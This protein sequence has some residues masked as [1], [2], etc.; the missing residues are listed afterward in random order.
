MLVDSAPDLSELRAKYLAAQLK[1]SRREAL[2]LVVDEGLARGAS[3]AELQRQVLQEAQ[4][5]IGRLWQENEI[6]IAQEHMATAISHAMLA[7]LYDLADRAPSRDRKVLVACVDGEL[8]D[9]P[10]RLVADALDLAGFETRYL[11]ASVPLEGL[12]QLVLSEQPHLIA[13][14]V[15]MPFNVPAL[16]TAVARLRV[17]TGGN[18]PIAVG[19]GAF[20]WTDEIGR[21]LGANITANS[22]EELVL[23]ASEL[24]G[25]VT[26][27]RTQVRP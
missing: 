6:S 14:S 13:L 11:G 5:E 8:H 23:A 4:R 1:G 25:G 2:R 21:E 17:A 16:Q 27:T 19:G 9:F 26:G 20:R 18:T 15:T 12:A 24:F 7:H 10:A 22:A 3:V